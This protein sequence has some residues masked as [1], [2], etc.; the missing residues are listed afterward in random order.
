VLGITLLISFRFMHDVGFTARRA[1]GPLTEVR[2]VLQA[3]IDAGWRNPPVRS[4]MLGGLFTGGV[5]FFAF[6]ASQP[7]LLQLYG[8][9]NA[10]SIAGLTAAIFAGA[11]IL[12]G[13]LVP[14]LRRVYR[15][16]TDGLLVSVV[17]TV[18]IMLVIGATTSFAL[19]LVLLAA[20]SMLFAVTSPFRQAFINGIIPSEQRATVLSFDSFMSAVGGAVS[21]PALGRVSDV[22]G[23]GP[24]YVVTGAIQA[25]AI[26]F[27]LLARR[28]RAASDPI[29]A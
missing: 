20:W 14:Y 7:Y 21:Q 24:A 18:G 3:S 16:R 6:Y 2:N 25:C 4:L 11:Q 22:Y 5:G 27:V 29:E 13:M 28:A 12:G 8:D 9:P 15:R 17:G 23:Y 26:P 19:A 1:A 10:Y